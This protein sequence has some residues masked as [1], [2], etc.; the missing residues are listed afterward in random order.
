MAEA[1]AIVLDGFPLRTDATLI[2]YPD[3]YDVG[4]RGPED[5]RDTGTPGAGTGDRGPNRG[6]V[7]ADPDPN[8]RARPPPQT[9]TA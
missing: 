4:D 9:P 8:A 5:G 6:G 3:R 7:M 1:G 2:C